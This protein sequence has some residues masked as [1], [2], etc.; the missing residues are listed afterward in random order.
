M[1][2]RRRFAGFTILELLTVV[3]VAGIIAAV[4]IPATSGLEAV[5]LTHAVQASKEAIEHA[6]SAAVATGRP[7]G[8]QFDPGS[9]TITLVLVEPGAG[10]PVPMAGPMGT[11]LEPT[12]LASR[13]GTNVVSVSA[14]EP[15]ENAIWFRF[16]GAPERRTGTGRLL[17]ELT[18]VAAV[19]LSKGSST[20]TLVVHGGSGL[21]EVVA[22]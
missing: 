16:D 9:A 10:A 8:A 22:R 14:S 7:T 21:V 11:P 4:V 13:Y 3:L 18:G 2:G 20:E 6:R 12:D 19:Q 5:R 17:G 1:S 15:V